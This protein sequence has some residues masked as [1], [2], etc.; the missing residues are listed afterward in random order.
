MFI[1]VNKNRSIFAS[2][3]GRIFD[4]SPKAIYEEMLKRD[5]FKDWDYL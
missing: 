1:P 5:K 2:Y 3:G 4:D